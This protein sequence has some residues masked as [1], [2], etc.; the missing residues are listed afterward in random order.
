VRLQLLSRRRRAARHQR[1]LAAAG[2]ALLAARDAA[3][4]HRV[5]AAA[6]AELLDQAAPAT[7]PHLPP[8]GDQS[9]PAE[10]RDALDTLRSQVALALERAA[11][12]AELTRRA[13]VDPLTGLANRTL[14]SQRLREALAGP[15]APGTTPAVLLL[16]LDDF[17]TI[18][19]SLGHSHGDEV[20]IVVAERLRACLQPD[21]L[22]ARLGG[23]EFAVLLPRVAEEA[24]AVAAAERLAA[25][26]R[27][28]VIVSGREVLARASVGVRLARG[29]ED[30][31]RLLRDADMAMYAAKTGGR[32]AVRVFDTA[33]HTRAVQRL[34]FEAALRRAVIRQ[35][36]T[37]RY[38]PVVELSE[39]RLA[40]LEA[41]VRWDHPER[42]LVM[43]GEFV[44]LAEDTGLIVPIGRWVLHAACQAARDWQR[45]FPLERPPFLSVNLSVRQLQQPDL[46]EDVAGA[47]DASGLDPAELMLEITESVLAT[48]QEAMLER[49][50]GLRALGVHLAIDDF[51]TGYSSLAYLRH[52]PVDTLKLA[53]PFVDELLRG[54]EEAALTNAI[55]RIADLLKLQVIAEGI[56]QQAQALELERLGCRYGQGFHFARPLDQFAVEALLVAE[57]AR[58]PFT[59]ARAGSRS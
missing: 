28:P 43:P 52:L 22:A 20:L 11:L 39:G 35:Q 38:Q 49:L 59:A 31:E 8:V 54:A 41:L 3:A 34:D 19:D 30:P 47:L 36:F 5:A 13:S 27:S 24:A 29:G 48:D 44:G 50:R 25:S 15:A 51:G 58:H 14:F 16:D 45:R 9:I 42:G 40:G 2:S 17:K 6:T 18:N 32:G 33:M 37:V 53:K 46:L 7:G 57:Q 10:V 26:L 23:D 21:D 55:L 4:V 1:L 12:S 56:E